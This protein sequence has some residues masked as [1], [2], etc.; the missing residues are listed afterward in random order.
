MQV[1]TANFVDPF[2]W[3]KLLDGL[4]DYMTRH[5]NE[6]YIAANDLPKLPVL[7]QLFPNVYRSAPVLVAA[8]QPRN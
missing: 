3:G 4:K 2:I 7:R 8:E 6:P 5:P 1:G